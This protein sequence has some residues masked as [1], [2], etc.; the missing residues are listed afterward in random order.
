MPRKTLRQQ[1]AQRGSRSRNVP[2]NRLR[3]VFDNV[4]G[5]ESSDQLMRQIVAALRQTT[6]QVPIGGKYYTFI[7]NA[8]TPE[9][10]TDRYPLV[11]VTGIFPWGFRGIN[12]HIYEIRN[13]NFN[14]LQSPLYEVFSGPEYDTIEKIPYQKLEY[15][16]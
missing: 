2:E 7:Y 15:T 4:T 5:A 13:Y 8:I 11:E 9:L 12:Y 16:S 3:P 14:Q 10:L 1:K 6:T